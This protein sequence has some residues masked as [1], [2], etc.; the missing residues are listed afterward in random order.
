MV[1][2]SSEA[3]PE[4]SQLLL[5]QPCPGSNITAWHSGNKQPT[6]DH[7]AICHKTIKTLLLPQQGVDLK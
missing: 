7:G 4:H 1:L 5:Y 2:C 6:P 3:G